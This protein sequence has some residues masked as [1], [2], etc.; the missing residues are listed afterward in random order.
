MALISLVK[1]SKDFGVRCLFKDLDLY[2]SKN[3]RLG[4]IGPNGSGKTTLLKLMY[5]ALKPTRGLVPLLGH[6]IALT[7][8]SE[9][10]MIRRQI[11]VV[12]QEF[13]LIPHLSAF[14][15]VALPLRISEESEDII[16]KHVK[17]LLVWVGLGNQIL[18]N[19]SILSGGQQQRVAIARALV[20]RPAIIL[21]DEP[22]G[23]VD[24]N[25]ALRLM[26]LFEE[27]NKTGTTVIIATHNQKLIEKLDH[28]VM[29]LTDGELKILNNNLNRS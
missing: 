7:P 13:R 10:P 17:E 15:N 23:N 12:F 28:P 4:L 8:R 3:E 27:L 25:I 18:A 6:D 1:A 11:G 14:D 29:E 9:L 5:L 2:I 16:E 21:A 24:D 19:P 26:H 22:T 20:N